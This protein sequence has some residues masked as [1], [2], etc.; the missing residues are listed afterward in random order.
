L[1]GNPADETQ[2]TLLASGQ[3]GTPAATDSKQFFYYQVAI[4]QATGK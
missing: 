4:Q 1:S 2:S 3:P